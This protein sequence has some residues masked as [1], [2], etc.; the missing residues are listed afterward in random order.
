MFL[1]AEI[2]TDVGQGMIIRV[3]T[4]DGV[5]TEE[6]AEIFG[7]KSARVQLAFLKGFGNASADN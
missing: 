7:E 3:T 1:K 5:V 4:E 6:D 2:E